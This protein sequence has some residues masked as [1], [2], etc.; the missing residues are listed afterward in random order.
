[1]RKAIA[2][3]ALALACAAFVIGLASAA[4][5][6]TATPTPSPTATA[7]S[8]AKTCADFATQAA[9]QAYFNSKGGSKTNNVDNLD[10]NRNGIACEGLP[11][12]PTA[13]A[14]ATVAPTATTSTLNNTG[15]FSDLMAMSGLS[16]LEI[17]VGLSLLSDR[18][19][20]GTKRAPLFVLKL[21]AKAA[22]QGH[23]EVALA[24]DVYIVRKPKAPEPVA[25]Q[26]EPVLSLPAE[27]AH[28]KPTTVLLTSPIGATPVTRVDP[29]DEFAIA[30]IGLADEQDDDADWPFFTPPDAS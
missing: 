6:Q 27:P 7:S 18:V 21:L 28:H 25:P 8:A 22:R 11:G 9:A 17:G 4:F 24:D 19:R 16:L 5:G 12:T 13:S 15:V 29:M 10:P 1:V 2:V 14:T 20:R 26:P 23:N 30:V 3:A